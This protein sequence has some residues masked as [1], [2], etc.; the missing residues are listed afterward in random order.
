MKT[1]LLVFLMALPFALYAGTPAASGS[2]IVVMSPAFENGQ[3]IPFF[4]SCQGKGISPQIS[5]SDIPKEA[6]SLVLICEDPDA[7]GGT[8][9]HWVAYNIPPQMLG[10]SSNVP[11]RPQLDDGTR[12]GKNSWGKIGY[13]APCPPS[14]PA[15]RYYFKVY[16]L[17]TTL[18]LAPGAAKDQVVQAM[19]GH[20]LAEG[21]LMGTY[22]RR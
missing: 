8:W 17:D 15:H 11:P 7:P 4:F 10:F 12:Q 5:W 22:Q 19:K 3:P 2:K 18:S 20:I 21:S 9:I 1:V 13:G 6:K 16:A 14:G